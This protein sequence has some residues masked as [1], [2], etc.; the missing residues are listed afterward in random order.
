MLDTTPSSHAKLRRRLYWPKRSLI[1]RD[2]SS[3]N[4]LPRKMYSDQ[5]LPRRLHPQ[6]LVRHHHSSPYPTSWYPLF[7]LL[8]IRLP[9]QPKART[10]GCGTSTSARSGLS[11][12]HSRAAQVD[13]RVRSRNGAS[14]SG[15]RETKRASGAGR[16]ERS[17]LGSW[18]GVGCWGYVLCALLRS[19]DRA[20]S[21]VDASRET[22]GPHDG[23]Y[24]HSSSQDSPRSF[25]GKSLSPESFRVP[26]FPERPLT[27]R[28]GP[29]YSSTP[30]P[31]LLLLVGQYPC[32]LISRWKGRYG[33]VRRSCCVKDGRPLVKLVDG[34]RSTGM[35]G[36]C[37]CW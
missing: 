18:K 7:Y 28:L 21:T 31:R 9:K 10:R 36:V 37:D 19:T 15:A 11:L 12:V 26:G 22:A 1:R 27:S 16:E 32:G 20:D 17:G 34:E 33:T 14:L 2:G 8:E 6:P 13:L 29:S 35:H 5:R 3:P 24:G 4:H 30:V 25:P 23:R